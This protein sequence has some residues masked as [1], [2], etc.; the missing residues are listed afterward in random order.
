MFK[1][2][3]VKS[4]LI[5]GFFILGLLLLPVGG[6]EAVKM[7]ATPP[8]E[9]PAAEQSQATTTVDTHKNSIFLDKETIAKGYT[10]TSRDKELKLSLVPG[11]LSED[12]RVET[13]TI[14]A[15][16]MD[17]PWRW[18]RISKIHQFDFA[19]KKSYQDKKP[20]YIQLSYDQDS[21][22]H[23]KVF[24]YDGNHDKWRP[25]P[26][27]DHPKENFVRSLIHLPF[28]R[29]AVFAN[30]DIM[31]SGKASWYGYKGG[32]F[33]ASPD[34]PKGSKLRVFNLANDEF[35]D[36]K[37]NDYG[38]DRSI[39]PDRVVDLDKQAFRKI[40]SLSE[41]IIEVKVEPLHIPD[42]EKF[43]VSGMSDKGA[44]IS[45]NLNS[46]AGIIR[47][48]QGDTL[49]RDGAQEVL[50]V[51]SLTKLVTVKVFLNQNTSLEKEVVY[52]DQDEKYNHKYCNPWESSRINLKKGDIVTAKDLIYSSLAGSANNAVETLVRASGLKREEFIKQMNQ[53]VRQIGA[54]DTHFVE[55]TGL[56]SNNVSSA[57][58]YAKI[59]AEVTEEP[60]IRQASTAESYEFTTQNTD[61]R[62]RVK[63]TNDLLSRINIEDRE[64]NI[65]TSKTG[66]LDE[67]GYCL[68]VD[69]NNLE[70]ED[71]VVLILDA[72]SRK[73]SFHQVED[74]IRYGF[75]KLD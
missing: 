39:F 50:P 23:K 26:T 67:A 6:A 58:N 64:F 57:Q 1:E 65:S 54:K 10:V 36:V 20:F 5:G 16:Q 30:P 31:T 46:R 56:S 43:R 75:K 40:S 18:D 13:R 42:Q 41:G 11:I 19:N 60:L 72:P 3:K 17:M 63:N 33:V 52:L 49:W 25:L 9:D 8:G 22:D 44:D 73:A 55:P 45:P 53:Y 14:P 34:F 38:P 2:V 71:F 62:L 47:T 12:T 69:V 29:I 48:E 51:A 37:V 68:A 70:G 27:T 28:A 74:L 4:G 61:R 15:E 7:G 59:I 35:V 24:F 32:D 21:W 66:Y